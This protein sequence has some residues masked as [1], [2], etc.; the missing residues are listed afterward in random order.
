MSEWKKKEFLISSEKD[1]EDI[2]IDI[3]NAYAKG[4]STM[5]NDLHEKLT[6]DAYDRGYNDAKNDIYSHLNKE[7]ETPI[8]DEDLWGDSIPEKIEVEP[9]YEKIK[10][11]IKKKPKKVIEKEN[12]YIK[13]LEKENKKPAKDFRSKAFR[14]MSELKDGVLTKNLQDKIRRLYKEGYATKAIIYLLKVTM[15]EISVTIPENE[16]RGKGTKSINV[17]ECKQNTEKALEMW[18]EGIDELK[19]IHIVKSVE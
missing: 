12:K 9:L 4:Y 10:E 13:K 14:E 15:T 11:R 2:I 7:P 16:K 8:K 18:A 1:I 17:K 5:R 3:D 19:I 6:K